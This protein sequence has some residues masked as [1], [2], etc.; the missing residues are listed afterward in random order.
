[1]LNEFLDG[2][3]AGASE[4]VVKYTDNSTSVDAAFNDLMNA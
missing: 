2:D 4:D 1:M 3:T